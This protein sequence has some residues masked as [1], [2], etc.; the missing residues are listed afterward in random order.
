MNTQIT[1]V[2]N[3]RGNIAADYKDGLKIMKDYCKELKHNL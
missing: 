1:D 2:R 3:E